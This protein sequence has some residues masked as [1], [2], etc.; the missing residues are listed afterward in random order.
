MQVT[1]GINVDFHNYDREIKRM[2]DRINGIVPVYKKVNKQLNRARDYSAISPKNKALLFRVYNDC[3]LKGNSKARIIAKVGRLIYGFELFKSKDVEVANKAD[4]QE[5][6]SKIMQDSRINET[7]KKMR[8]EE[9]KRLD[10]EY[11]G[12]G[13]HY[14]ERTKWMKFAKVQ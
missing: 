7:T 1:S 4:F 8:V 13:E 2:L 12:E 9:L 3:V 5:V 14:T 11:F 6:F 10:R